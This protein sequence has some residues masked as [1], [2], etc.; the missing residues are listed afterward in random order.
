MEEEVALDVVETA[1]VA[2]KM[3]TQEQ[4]NALIGREK[5]AAAEKARRDLEAQYR[6]QREQEASTPPQALGSNNVNVD[7]IYQQ[8]ES[9]LRQAE[10]ERQAE[11]QTK[12]YQEQIQNVANTYM[13]KINSGT[14]EELYEDFADV[15]KDFDARKYPGLVWLVSDMDNVPQVMYDL[16]SNPLKLAAINHLAST[17]ETQARKAL[18]K[19]SQSI[20]QNQSAVD[21]YAST[22]PPISRMKPSNVGADKESHTLNDFKN[23]AWL[24]G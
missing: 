19:L 6:A 8:V 12:A 13:Q 3:L 1:P 9:R 14:G 21:N 22:K 16:A 2:E 24:R 7:D 11:A 23:A 20:V 15:M 17:D 5:A 10:E 4:V 18:Q